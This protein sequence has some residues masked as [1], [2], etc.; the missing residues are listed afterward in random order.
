LEEGASTGGSAKLCLESGSL[1]TIAFLTHSEK[2]DEN[3]DEKKEFSSVETTAD[4]KGEDGERVEE[5]SS[6]IGSGSGGMDFLPDI[7][8][9]IT[10]DDSSAG[11]AGPPP[12]ID[13]NQDNEGED[14]ETK[15]EKEEKEVEEEKGDEN[16]TAT[17]HD[18]EDGKKGGDDEEVD[19]KKDE[20]EVNEQV[21]G[22]VTGGEEDEEET[23]VTKNEEENGN[24]EEENGKDEEETGS[25]EGKVVVQE[26]EGEEEEIDA[27][28]THTEREDNDVKKT[29]KQGNEEEEEEDPF[30]ISGLGG[31]NGKTSEK[32]SGLDPLGGL[33]LGFTSP[34]KKEASSTAPVVTFGTASLFGTALGGEENSSLDSVSLF[35][36]GKKLNLAAG[37]A[38]KPPEEIDDELFNEQM[39]KF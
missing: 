23:T 37:D 26:G 30:D 24:D 11:S 39:F 33:S 34:T 15:E 32:S 35:G 18:E 20:E 4:D 28:A 8:D 14:V 5:G 27:T 21:N 9:M 31:D 6:L 3:E 19:N 2:V 1:E 36:G 13:N 10:G 7:G 29:E 12:V 22:T 25:G 16:V 38:S 17:H